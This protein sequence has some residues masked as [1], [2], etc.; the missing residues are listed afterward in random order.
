MPELVSWLYLEK[1]VLKLENK[2]IYAMNTD[3]L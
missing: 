2:F 1:A 3:H